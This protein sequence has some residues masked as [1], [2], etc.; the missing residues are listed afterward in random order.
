MKPTNEPIHPP[1][2]ALLF[3]FVQGMTFAG[4]IFLAFIAAV[5]DVIIEIVTSWIIIPIGIVTVFIWMITN[6]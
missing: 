4:I 3:C 5:I 1:K 2:S 6:T